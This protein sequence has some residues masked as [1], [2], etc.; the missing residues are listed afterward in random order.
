LWLLF[1]AADIYSGE[2]KQKAQPF[3]AGL[4]FYSDCIKTI[5]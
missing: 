3:Q 4:S 2:K 1:I 5:Y